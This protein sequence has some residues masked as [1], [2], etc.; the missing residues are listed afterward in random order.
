MREGDRPGRRVSGEGSDPVRNV[1]GGNVPSWPVF[2]EGRLGPE[3]GGGLGG[4]ARLSRGGG[5][6]G[7][8]LA[9]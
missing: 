1:R 7:R 9:G 6:S 5:S 2:G 8:D 4:G 3:G